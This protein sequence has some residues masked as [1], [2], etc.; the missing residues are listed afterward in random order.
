[1]V[2]LL[3][4]LA[5]AAGGFLVG[6]ETA[7]DDGGGGETAAVETT[8]STSTATESESAPATTE[9]ATTG[10]ADTG[11]GEDADGKAVFARA[12]CGSCHTFAPAGANG[13]VG[14]NLNEIDLS[15]DEIEQQVRNGGGG[16]PPFEGRL[17]D[18]QIEAVADFVESGSKG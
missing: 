13:T 16:M 4:M 18:G 1:M 9:A 3:L 14:P 5:A 12:G 7:D 11:G 15:K 2:A 17:S 10:A 6:R 8:A